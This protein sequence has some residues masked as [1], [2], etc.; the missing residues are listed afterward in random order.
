[1]WFPKSFLLLPF[2]LKL[3]VAGQ[4]TENQLCMAACDAALSY[5]TFNGS[6]LQSYYVAECTNSLRV[7][8]MFV[9]SKT[10][11]KES[12]IQPGLNYFEKYCQTY[13]SVD[14]LPYSIISNFTTESIEA[15]RQVTT[16]DLLSE[17]SFDEVVLLSKDL[18][19]VSWKTV[20]ML[21]AHSCSIY[22]AYNSTGFLGI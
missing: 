15:L 8:S 21:T 17:E 5:L 22:R 19:D 11:C 20:V 6:E 10:Y 4:L 13:G 12:D 14:L 1:M 9:C 18:Y 7:Q 2:L 16:A 3:A